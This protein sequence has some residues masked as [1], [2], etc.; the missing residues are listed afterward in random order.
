[1]GGDV[2]F[3]GYKISSKKGANYCEGYVSFTPTN[4]LLSPLILLSI[5]IGVVESQIVYV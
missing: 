4:I 3:G 2:E 5:K 1:M